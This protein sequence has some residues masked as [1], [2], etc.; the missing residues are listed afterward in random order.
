MQVEP[1]IVRIVER[2]DGSQTPADLHRAM[3]DGGLFPS[4]AGED[5][6]REIIA[7]LV[8][9]GILYPAGAARQSGGQPVEALA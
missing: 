1:G 7:A 2:C 5:P 9:A 4:D 6:F 8:S 3:V